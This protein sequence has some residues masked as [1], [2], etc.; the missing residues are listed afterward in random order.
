LQGPVTYE[1]ESVNGGYLAIGK[2]TARM[3]N[4]LRNRV[5]G[6]TRGA[7]PESTV[8]LFA[9]RTPN[10]TVTDLSTEF[11]VEV[12][13]KGRTTS[14]VFRGSIKV[15]LLGAGPQKMG[16]SI[17]LRE[18]ESIRAEKDDAAGG[19]GVVM[20]RVGVKPS[21]FVRR[22]S[23]AA[24]SLDLL[25]IVAGGNGRGRHRE[26]GIDPGRGMESDLFLA[27][28]HD[29]SQGF[30]RVRFHDPVDGVFIPSGNK[31]TEL[32]SAGHTFSGFP[33]TCG[34]SYGLI[35]ARAADLPNT[36]GDKNGQHWV[37]QLKNGDQLMP[38][39]RGL[40]CM[41]ADA[42]IAFNLEAMR[43][44]YPGRR[45]IRLRAVGGVAEAMPM[46]C[47]A[48]FDH[49]IQ[50]WDQDEEGPFWNPTGGQ[51]GGCAIATRK[52]WNPYLTPPVSS[53]LYGDLPDTFGCN[54]IRFSYYLKNFGGMPADGGRLYMFADTDEDGSWDTL[55]EWLPS[56]TSV[57]REWRHYTW[58]IDMGAAEAPQGWTRV[59]GTGSWSASWKHVKYWNFWTGRGTDDEIRNGIDSLVVA[60]VPDKSNSVAHEQLADFWVFVD[61]K[62]RLKREKLRPRDGVVPINVEL[63]GEDRFL[64]IV[65]TNGGNGNWRDWV[66]FGDPVIDM[67]PIGSAAAS[68]AP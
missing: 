8:P 5:Q 42:G 35:W 6:P 46:V 12:D 62:L 43:K 33:P 4:G 51:S 58:T 40:L 53:I 1:V 59:N 32:D 48:T 28:Q 36:D 63:R 7:R 21:T 23:P 49:S 25:D 11:G 67:A 24:T 47:T 60:G 39:H 38:D 57:P 3:E 44:M 37:Y 56:D 50:G 17:I 18:N 20:S 64:T 22:I 27:E 26:C 66:V 31:G 54:L 9:V 30:R 68:T 65:S 16:N 2:L 10:A 29:G 15:Q 14:H 41:H 52:R 19:S 55:W 45:P 34:T 61:G 13:A